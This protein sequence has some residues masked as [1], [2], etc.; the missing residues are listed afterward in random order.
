[1]D[2][3]WNCNIEELQNISYNRVTPALQSLMMPSNSRRD[4]KQASIV[5]GSSLH[6]VWR[7]SS[8]SDQLQTH[9]HN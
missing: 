5:Y 3:E 4:I 7:V 1:M 6:Y 8:N 9:P 2:H